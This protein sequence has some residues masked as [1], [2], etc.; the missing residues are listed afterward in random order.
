[1]K[2]G[3]Q[4]IH[5]SETHHEWLKAEAKRRGVKMRDLLA[6]IITNALDAE[7]R[8][9]ETAARAKVGP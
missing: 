1:M 5:V 4:V 3:G 8:R 2:P 6:S 7:E 9:A